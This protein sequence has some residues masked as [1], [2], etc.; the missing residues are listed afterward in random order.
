[1]VDVQ[2]LG[3][4]GAGLMGRGIAQVA[5]A[6]G[7]RVLL[8]D[9]AAGVAE[10]ARAS[11]DATLGRQ[12]A[13][14]Q[15]EEAER[16][17][18]VGAVEPVAEVAALAAAEY[19]I[20]AVPEQLE[21][22]LRVLAEIDAVLRDEAVMASNTSSLSIT[23]L[24]TASRRP[25]RVVGMHF[26]NPAP[27]LPLVELVV[28]QQTDEG[29]AATVRTVAERMGKTVIATRD[30]P[31]FVVNRLLIPYLNE[32]CLVLEAGLASAEDLDAAVRLGLNHPLGPLRLADLIGLDT[33]L[34]IGEVLERELG[35]K[36]R[37][38]VLLR[39]YVAAGW[40]GRKSGRGF[41]SY[42]ES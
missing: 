12:V 19:V 2:T 1:M 4:V 17:R 3:V 31:G 38:A 36:Y 26:F 28:G 7:Y 22:K 6:A 32:A 23:R 18:I 35:D 34:A 5:A 16:A 9:A 11:I 29:T 21:L 42:G 40:L 30:S 10:A 39:Q 13:R 37:P 15:L 8:V 24:A 25:E 14:G 41:F 20:E 33:V 27:V